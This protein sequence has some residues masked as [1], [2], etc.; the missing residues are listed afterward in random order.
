MLGG[1]GGSRKKTEFE[2]NCC[3]FVCRGEFLMQLLYIDKKIMYAC[4][5]ISNIQET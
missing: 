3:G 2:I 1:G 4:K 5:K